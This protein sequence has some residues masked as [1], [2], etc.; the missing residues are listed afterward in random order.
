MYWSFNKDFFQI[1]RLGQ[2]RRKQVSL[3]KTVRS[4]FSEM[5]NRNFWEKFKPGRLIEQDA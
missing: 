3:N 5:F 2:Q 1:S 4:I